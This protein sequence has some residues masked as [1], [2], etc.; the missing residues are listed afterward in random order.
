MLLDTLSKKI[1]ELLKELQRTREALQQAHNTITTLNSQNEEKAHQ[2]SKLYE[3]IAKRDAETQNLIDKIKKDLN[4]P[5][6][7]LD[8]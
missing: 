1:Q 8:E 2:I 3:E 4:P 5:Q 6:S 7:L